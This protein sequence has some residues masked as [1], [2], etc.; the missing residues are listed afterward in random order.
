MTFERSLPMQPAVDSPFFDAEQS[1]GPLSTA[2]LRDFKEQGYLVL[3]DLFDVSEL[4]CIVEETRDLYDNDVPD[5]PRSRIRVLDVWGECPHVRSLACDERIMS[6]LRQLYGREPIPFQTLNFQYGTEQ[7]A[8]QDRMFFSSL[9]SDFM[10]GVWVALE[11]VSLTNGTLFY[12]PG[13][14]RLAELWPD[15]LGVAPV[16]LAREGDQDPNRAREEAETMLDRLLKDGGF[17]KEVL[18]AKKGTALIWAAGLAHGGSPIGEPGRTRYSQVTHYF[19]SDC[20]YYT[21]IYTNHF[22]GDLYLKGVTNIVTGEPVQHRYGGLDVE[23]V[24]G[25]GMYK[26]S[27]TVEGDREFVQASDHTHSRDHKKI[28]EGVLGSRSYRLGRALTAPVRLLRGR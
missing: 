11:D 21:P 18:E 7:H 12:H 5:G 4:D 23:G 3:E 27:V 13:S 6:A 1:Q 24:E 28:L 15:T 17:G 10:C 26:L 22:S 19:F 20:L 8:H 9:P 16:N 2:Q 14:Q 25:N